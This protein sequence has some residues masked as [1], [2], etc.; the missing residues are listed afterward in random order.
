MARIDW[1]DA[2]LNNWA[3]WR[4]GG[5]S[6]GLGYSHVQL[7]A[8]VVDGGGYDTPAIIPVDDAEASIT[9]QAVMTLP[10]ELRRTV[11]VMYVHPGG[12][13]TKLELLAIARPTLYA[14]LDA[15]DRLIA[16]WLGDRDRTSRA[17][18]ERVE[19]LQRLQI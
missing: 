18:R 11:E 9:D 13:A 12:V 8:P 10:S 4:I 17:E 5:R 3:R 6:G 16:S 19:R 15:A 2:R 7:E 1:I 14:R